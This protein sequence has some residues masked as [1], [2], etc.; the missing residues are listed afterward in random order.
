MSFK[1]PQPLIISEDVS[2]DWTLFKNQFLLFLTATEA[3]SKSDQVKVAQLLNVIGSEAL[4]IFY[5]FKL[6]DLSELTQG[7]L[8]QT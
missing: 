6:G 2:T 3:E 5:T 1:P 8:L 4:S 7:P